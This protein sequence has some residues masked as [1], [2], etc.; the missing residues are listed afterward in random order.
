M[1][2]S[3]VVVAAA[4][5]SSAEQARPGPFS[6]D[7]A[8]PAPARTWSVASPDGRTTI[9]ASL[10]DGRL[11]WRAARDGA[12]VVLDSPMG[13]RRADA[14]FVDGLTFAASSDETR[15]DDRYQM[16]HGKRREHRAQGRQRTLTFLKS[17]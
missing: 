7:R 16:P 1:R 8:I 5:V 3:L 10:A 14:S 2:V 6:R 11:T 9:A 13:I 12:A 15:I 17:A 4:L